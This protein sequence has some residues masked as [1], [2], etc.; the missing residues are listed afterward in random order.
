MMQIDYYPNYMRVRQ[1]KEIS[2]NNWWWK[3]DEKLSKEQFAQYISP[4]LKTL[5]RLS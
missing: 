4:I 5:K 3:S 2:V 1:G